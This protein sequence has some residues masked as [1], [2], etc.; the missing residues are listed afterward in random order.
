VEE[1]QGEEERK[2]WKGRKYEYNIAVEDQTRNIIREKKQK[3]NIG[4]SGEES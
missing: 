4:T 1:E 2:R 3:N